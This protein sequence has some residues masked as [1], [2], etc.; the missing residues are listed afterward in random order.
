M[1]TKSQSDIAR[2]EIE[3]M[4]VFGEIELSTLYSEN[5][6]ASLLNLGR[7]PVR[8]A[9]QSL[10]QENMLKIHP[11]KGVEFLDTSPEQQVLLLEV[12]RQIEPICIRFAIMRGT[13]EQ[14]KKMLELG[15]KIC[16]SAEKKDQ[17]DILYCLQNIHTLLC[18]ATQ[19]PYFHNAL[20]QIQFFSR[21]FWFANKG[22]DDDI[23]AAKIH[24]HILRSV[25][26][27]NEKNALL[28]S[29]LLMEHLTEACFRP[30]YK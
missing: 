13:F 16:D 21:R 17:A 2:Q 10:E 24:R 5:K 19:N 15:E 8:E 1:H 29:K 12:R 7:T 6:L 25:V 4:I 9:I 30:L 3:R 20:S 18:D 22:I 26:S 23:K 11:R 27:A 14:K 28:H